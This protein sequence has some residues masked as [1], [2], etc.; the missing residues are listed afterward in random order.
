MIASKLLLIGL[1]G[2]ITAHV[3]CSP[4]EDASQILAEAIG[5]LEQ[6]FP[7]TMRMIFWSNKLI[8]GQ[9]E[10]VER[11]DLMNTTQTVAFI[12]SVKYAIRRESLSS[13]LD[14]MRE[15]FVVAGKDMLLDKKLNIEM[16]PEMLA[17]LASRTIFR[18]YRDCERFTVPHWTLLYKQ[19]KHDL[20]TYPTS[21]AF[22]QLAI[23]AYQ[24][25]LQLSF[26]AHRARLGFERDLKVTL[27]AM[28]ASQGA[29]VVG[30]LDQMIEEMLECETCATASPD[31]HGTRPLFDGEAAIKRA[32]SEHVEA[33]LQGSFDE[34]KGLFE[35][36]F[37]ERELVTREEIDKL[38][39]QLIESL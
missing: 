27:A 19:I 31:Q 25:M 14:A 7:Q 26:D 36:S 17:A 23:S 4:L 1:V 39:Q 8:A 24:Q 30:Q 6:T 13:V 21:K 34:I 9:M 38:M 15:R 5:V 28:E 18:A 3:G 35:V 20:A 2:F 16:R 10:Q 32:L 29:Q 22:K 12:E 33:L 37:E 11:E